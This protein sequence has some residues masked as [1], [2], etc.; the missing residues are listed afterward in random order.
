MEKFCSAKQ[1]I[2]HFKELLFKMFSLKSYLQILEL[3][4]SNTNILETHKQ[5]LNTPKSEDITQLKQSILHKVNLCE[6]I[7]KQLNL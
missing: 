2:L 5:L 1:L 7:K 3:E 6:E 4:A